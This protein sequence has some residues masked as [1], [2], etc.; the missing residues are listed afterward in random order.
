MQAAI[1]GGSDEDKEYAIH[2]RYGPEVKLN[3]KTHQCG[4]FAASLMVFV[5]CAFSLDSA[6]SPQAKTQDDLLV[7]KSLV[8]TWRL[9][10]WPEKLA[11]GTIRQNEKDSGYLIYTSSGRM[12][13]VAMNAERPKWSSAVSPTPE[14]IASTFNGFYAYCG[15]VEVH[16]KEGFILHHV[17]IDKSPNFVGQTR[18][19]W[20]TFH[21]PNRISLRIDST[22]NS[23][24]VVESTL[25]WERVE[26]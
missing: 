14:E 6:P 20:L 25:V 9:V 24:P 19:R 2:P 5:A 22:E 1:A 3:L 7:A 16:A 23:P 13:Y 4:F 18:K 21:G 12:C 10:S 17:E 15:T 8:G 11:D 26:K